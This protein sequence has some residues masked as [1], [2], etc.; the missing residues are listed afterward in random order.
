MTIT[1]EEY[2]PQA[3]PQDNSKQT[4]YFKNNAD[5]LLN[6]L[7]NKEKT[8]RHPY[9]PD[10]SLDKHEP[11]LNKVAAA[12]ATSSAFDSGESFGYTDTDADGGGDGGGG[13]SF[14]KGMALTKLEKEHNIIDLDELYDKVFELYD[15]YKEI[16]KTNIAKHGHS[17]YMKNEHTILEKLM[18]KDAETKNILLRRYENL[19]FIYKDRNI[20]FNRA[21]PLCRLKKNYDAEVE[22]IYGMSQVE[23]YKEYIRYVFLAI[24]LIAN[25]VGFDMSGYTKFQTERM[26][27]Y[28][29]ILTEIGSVPAITKLNSMHPLA[30]LFLLFFFN[31]ICFIGI[32]VAI[33]KDKSGGLIFN[34]IASVI[35]NCFASGGAPPQSGSAH[36]HAYTPFGG[37]RTTSQGGAPQ[38]QVRMRG[39]TL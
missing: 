16:K 8:T 27:K 19:S 13:G 17:F 21:D 2:D 10:N 32:K 24:E 26:D 9:F 20:K 6:M 7:D 18:K 22:R 29:R 31:T 36:P 5:L 15:A 30:K 4:F 12:A 14:G 1:L 23:S 3:N 11:S 35:G 38:P 33:K 39:P 37:A 28:E 34:S 25:F